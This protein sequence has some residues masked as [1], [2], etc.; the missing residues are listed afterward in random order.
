MSANTSTTLSTGKIL[1]SGVKPTGRPHIG[2]YFGAMKQ[3]V[4]LQDSYESRIFVANLHALTTLQDRNELAINARGM[5][6][7][8]LS[9]GLDPSKTT[10][11]YQSDV[12]HI[13]ELAWILECI[14][15]M[16]YLMRAHAFKDAEAKNKEIN[17]GVF[18]YPL[19]MAADILIHDADVVPVGKDQKQHVEIA[20]DTAEKFNTIFGETFKIPE[21][22]ILQDVA[23]V[24]G[25]DGQKMSKSYN[26]TIPLFS[27]D[28]EIEK[29]VMSIVTDSGQDVPKNVYEIHKLVRPESELKK[30]YAEKKGQYKEL[31]IELIKDLKN[32][33]API[34]ARRAEWESKPKE[35]D[36]ILAEGG[37]KMRKIVHEKMIEVR[38]KV[39]LIH[40][41]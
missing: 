14:T 40:N 7:D 18:N 5:A 32:F 28:E 8:Y 22:L 11:Y 26:N 24:P 13:A 17:V 19:L 4:D 29:T 31:K 2:N 21:P 12:P 15:T 16:P 9:I 10:L 23:T 34:R 1:V 27:S 6:I 35:V 38:K 39:G 25:I 30:L 20:R 36:K 41:E 37:K 3:F 33:I